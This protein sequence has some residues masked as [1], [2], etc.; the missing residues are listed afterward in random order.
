MPDGVCASFAVTGYPADVGPGWLEPLLTYP[1]RLEVAVHVEPTPP[2]VAA[3]RLRRQLARLESSARSDASHGRLEDFGASAAADDARGLAAALA[4][5]QT[6]LFRVG[7][8]FTVHARDDEALETEC[9]RVRALT[10]SLLL[11]AAPATFRSVQGLATTLPLG[12][13]ALKMRRTFD[14]SALA[15]SFP[16]TSPDMDA[17]ITDTTVLYGINTASSSL[18]MWDRWGLDNHN[19]VVLARSGAGKSYLTKLEILRSLYAG[20]E[21]AVIDPEDEYR[22]LCEAVGGSYIALGSPGVKLNP[23]DLPTSTTTA[24][25]DAFTRRALFLHT[26]IGVL[27]D[28]PLDPAGKAALD[29]AIVEVYARAGITTDPRTW[30]R[31][32]PLLADLAAALRDD[33]EDSKA[34]EVAARLAPF[35][36]GTHRDLFDSAT[37]TRPDGHLLVFSLRDLPDELRAAGTLLALDAVWRRVSN[38]RQRRRRLVVVDEAWLLMREPDGAKFLFRLAKSARKYWCGLAVVTQDA[39]DLLDTPLGQAV[40][41]NATT[42]ILLRQAPQAIDAVG[43][44]FNLSAGERQ[45]LL[46]CGRGEGL[47]AA[48]SDRVSFRSIASP[49]EHGVI[50]SDPAE[51]ADLDP[52][53]DRLHIELADDELEVEP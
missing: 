27:L 18:V 29:R 4:R 49:A 3:D 50:T 10:S 53:D 21:V 37:S 7:L 23:F 39:A 36:T 26:L 5:G 47:L 35:V 25:A 38:P 19:S 8:Y 14:T 45:F 46:G 42:Q 32:A 34:H 1:G 28:E 22:R 24:G 17:P 52:A 41:A 44:A 20:I 6:K 13:D 43:D 48:G 33:T 2:A 15:A 51:L 12:V 30:T 31:P 40:I 16:F 9:S 11:D